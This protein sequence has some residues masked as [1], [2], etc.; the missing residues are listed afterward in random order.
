VNGIQ[1]R[2]QA[3]VTSLINQL[4]AFSFS[5]VRIFRAI[6]GVVKCP[7]QTDEFEESSSGILRSLLEITH[8][9]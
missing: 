7:H 6:A 4:V 5:V 9:F 8:P 1:V 2:S 3:K